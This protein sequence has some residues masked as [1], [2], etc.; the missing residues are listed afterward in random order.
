MAEPFLGE[1]RVFS[2]GTIPKGWLPCNGQ[3]LAISQNTALFALLGTTYGGNGVN[4]FALPDLRGRVGINA[5]TAPSG[6]TYVQGETG[7]SESVT[8]TSS[9]VPPHSHAFMASTVTATGQAPS[10]NVLAPI[11]G[12]SL[13][14]AAPATLQ[15]LEVN[16]VTPAGGNLP[17]ENRQPS[18]VLSYCIAT[19]GIFPSRP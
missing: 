7:G 6:T 19:S 8:L 13:A 15:A 4:N 16:S 17:H 2:F 9:T 11:A 1:I 12:G 18:L 10:G 14:F 3:I 5:G